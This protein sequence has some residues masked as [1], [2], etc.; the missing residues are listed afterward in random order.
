AT[1]NGTAGTQGVDPAYYAMRDPAQ[2]QSFQ[3]AHPTHR[4]TDRIPTLVEEKPV[5]K[6]TVLGKILT[7][8]VVVL[9][10]VALVLG[11]RM[12]YVIGPSMGLDLPDLTQLPVI[13]NLIEMLP[14]DEDTSSQLT[15]NTDSTEEETETV[16][17]TSIVLDYESIVLTEGESLV[18]T[19]T[20][21]VEDWDGS[22][23]W[24]ASDQEEAIFTVTA[25]SGTTAEVAYVGEGRGALSAV[26][27]DV[28][29]TCQITC[30]AANVDDEDADA[31]VEEDADSAK[32][33]AT[34][35]DTE[36][37]EHIDIELKKDDFTLN[38]GESYA[39]MDENADQV[40]WTSSNSAV[41]TVND[42]GVVTAVSSGNATITA[43]GPDGTTASSIARVR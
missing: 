7:F 40:T 2:T 6:K 21:D 26:V 12:L 38:V 4:D 29:V 13:S 33:D 14:S 23:T 16:M 18:I 20:T 27:G 30:E 37:A 9:V 10:I 42:N 11:V 22:I 19:A 31:A 17:P 28:V 1:A 25:L 24:G 34:E 35:D 43:T 8:V 3:P 41:A 5:R 32:T 15:T 36:A 39:L